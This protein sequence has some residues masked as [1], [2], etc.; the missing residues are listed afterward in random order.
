MATRPVSLMVVTHFC[1]A[2]GEEHELDASVTPLTAEDYITLDAPSWFGVNDFQNDTEHPDGI[3][4]ECY[5]AFL[6]DGGRN[7]PAHDLLG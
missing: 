2:C 5:D 1:T 4:G 7:F 6:M 3:C